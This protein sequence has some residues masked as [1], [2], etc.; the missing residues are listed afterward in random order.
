ML[1]ELEKLKITNCVGRRFVSTHCVTPEKSN[2]ISS[3]NK[4]VTLKL[5]T[6]DVLLQM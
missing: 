1:T 4:T 6:S 3:D 2:Q 5:A